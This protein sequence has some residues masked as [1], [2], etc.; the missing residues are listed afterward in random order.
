MLEG[1]GAVG[2]LAA[3][4]DDAVI[5]TAHELAE[6]FEATVTHDGRQVD[7][8]VVGSRA[9]A[10]PGRLMLSGQAQR[11]LENATCPVLVVPR[12]VTISFTQLATL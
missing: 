10:A 1:V 7:L 2:V 8:L 4:G 5:A 3:P 11:E 9:E 6:S 12:G